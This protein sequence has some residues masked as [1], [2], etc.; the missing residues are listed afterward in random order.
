MRL[1]WL[2]NSVNA[3]DDFWGGLSEGMFFDEYFIFSVVEC[4]EVVLFY[5]VVEYFSASRTVPL[6]K[7][8][9]DYLCFTKPWFKI[10]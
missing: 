7:F 3:C 2:C 6:V 5:C 4:F 1:L 10:F 9:D 8:D